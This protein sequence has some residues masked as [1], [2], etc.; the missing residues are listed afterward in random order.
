MPNPKCGSVVPSGWEGSTTLN[1]SVKTY[2]DLTK[3]V[4]MQFGWPTVDVELCDQVI[5]DNINQ[6]LEWYSK[7]AGYT[8]EYM[9]FDSK[10]YVKGMGIKMDDVFSMLG[11]TYNTDQS[12][13]SGRIFDY[14]LEDYRKVISVHSFDPVEYSGTDYLFTLDYMFAQQTYFSHMM[15][16]FGFD[17]VTWH[18]LKDWL[19]LRSKLF[20]TQ[21]QVFF[22]KNTQWMRLIPEPNNINTRYVG[23]IGAWVEKSICNMIAERWV[24]QYSTALSMIQIGNIRGKFGNVSLMG[25]G[26]VQWNDVL[27]QGIT[28]KAQLEEELMTKFGESMPLGIFVG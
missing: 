18:V 5:Y 25:G 10:Q 20:A 1:S 16:N 4:K 15:G 24:Y 22:D 28:M 9:M 14:D 6:A 7:Y 12:E 17:L 27:Q 3:R 26:A 23:V 13:V 11:Q 21:P 8:E 19:E 2:D